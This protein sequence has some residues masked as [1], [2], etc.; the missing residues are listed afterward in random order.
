MDVTSETGQPLTVVRI[1]PAGPPGRGADLVT[2]AP[3]GLCEKFLEDGLWG[4]DSRFRAGI[5][6]SR[7][8]RP[9]ALYPDRV[10]VFRLRSSRERRGAG[11]V[12][13]T[14]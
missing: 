4:V 8:V 11:G 6:G 7:V 13:G 1:A 10:M 2:K 3:G 5:N 9:A 12:R 14:A